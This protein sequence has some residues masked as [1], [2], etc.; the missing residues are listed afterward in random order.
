VLP[1]LKDLVSVILLP[2][3]LEQMSLDVHVT[4]SAHPLPFKKSSERKKE[5]SYTVGG[6]VN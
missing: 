1:R 5:P 2:H 4:V 3:P 6:N